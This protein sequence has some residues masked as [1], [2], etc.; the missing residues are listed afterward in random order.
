M[1]SF[2]D[3]CERK[4]LP[5][6]LAAGVLDGAA[7][8]I[9]WLTDI[10]AKKTLGAAG[11]QI[12][13]IT[14]LPSFVLVLSLFWSELLKKGAHQKRNLLIVGLLGR[15]ILLFALLT[16][17]TNGILLLFFLYHLSSAML[18][19]L[20]TSIFEHNYRE[21]IRGRIYGWFTSAFTLASMIAGLL[22]GKILDA[23]EDAFRVL[24]AAAGVAGL[25]SCL[26]FSL[27]TLNRSGWH[28]SE[29][30]TEHPF[31]LMTASFRNAWQVL[32]TDGL[33][34]QY[35]SNFSIYGLGFFSVLPVLP[36]FL[37]DTLHLSYGEISLGRGVIGQAGL[38]L[39]SPVLGKFM[40]RYKPI[41]F[42]GLM[43]T[44]LIAYPL[45]LMLAAFVPWPKLCVY[46]GFLMFG[47]AM[48]GVGLSWRLGSLYF[49]Q[50]RPSAA[51]LTVHMSNAGLRGVVMPPVGY[52]IFSHLGSLAAFALSAILLGIASFRMRR[53]GRREKGGER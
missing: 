21:E 16:H 29:T 34:R 23:D 45:L 52:L 39:L 13:V 53:L 25:A 51:Y 33:F 18:I 19:F 37:V 35:Q 6:L 22:A 38:V 12:T 27:V 42:T 44:L 30:G 24:Y 2:L 50:G 32:K 5:L 40:D 7:S 47:V 10:I 49:T 36:Y 26:L 14:M 20:V 15:L 43:L 17:G 4:W 46:A 1:F 3:T 9:L 41:R 8:G 48:A 28:A 31:Q 11:W